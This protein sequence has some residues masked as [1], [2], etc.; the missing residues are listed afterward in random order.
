MRQRRPF[1]AGRSNPC[2]GDCPGRVSPSQSIATWTDAALVNR[3]ISRASLRSRCWDPRDFWEKICCASRCWEGFRWRNILTPRS[4]CRIAPPHD[5]PAGNDQVPSAQEAPPRPAPVPGLQRAAAPWRRKPRPRPRPP[6]SDSLRG[7][8][9]KIGTIQRR[10]AWPLRKDDT[11]KSRSVNNFFPDNGARPQLATK[12]GVPAGD[13]PSP[14]SASAP[15]REGSRLPV[16]QVG[17]G[18]WSAAI[19]VTSC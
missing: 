18:W 16:T 7:S 12:P 5:S 13:A 15:T 8:S 6:S 10:L 2:N 1:F 3:K 4:S 19:C 11:H 14:R 9:V 17:G